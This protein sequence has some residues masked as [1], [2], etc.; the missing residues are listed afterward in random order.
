MSHSGL[1]PRYEY[2]LKNFKNKPWNWFTIDLVNLFNCV[3][4]I[5]FQFS[6]FC[7]ELLNCLWLQKGKLFFITKA[8]KSRNDKY[9]I[10]LYFQL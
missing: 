1:L 5:L 6:N 3:Y 8:L 2:R 4:Y 9:W 10:I 7:Q